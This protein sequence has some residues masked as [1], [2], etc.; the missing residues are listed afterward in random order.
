MSFTVS[1]SVGQTFDVAV[2]EISTVAGDEAIHAVT[3][4][5][6]VQS[7]PSI[8]TEDGMAMAIGGDATAVGEDTLAVAEVSA[9]LGDDGN[10]QIAS[11]SA[12]FLA[13]GEGD[14]GTYA[15]AYSYVDFVGD[16]DQVVT[17]NVSVTEYVQEPDQ[18]AW[19]SSSESTLFAMDVDDIP[20]G[21]P[22]GEVAEGGEVF[23]PEPYLEL[24]LTVEPLEDPACGC[25]GDEPSYNIDDNL[26][27]FDVSATAV[28]DNTVVTVDF[29]GLAVEDQLST[30]T[31]AVILGIE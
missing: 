7:G 24:P 1:S 14:P 20:A 30:A 17:L 28:A 3:I 6:D 4:A 18:A 2:T 27:L 29:F 13:I 8:S 19:Y 16:A 10:V 23:E 12:Y 15:N 9:F 26:V 31:V 21:E 22:V 5:S 25:S 11:G